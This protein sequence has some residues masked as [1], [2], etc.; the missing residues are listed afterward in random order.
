MGPLGRLELRWT[1]NY[2]YNLWLYTLMLLLQSPLRSTCGYKH[3]YMSTSLHPNTCSYVNEPTFKLTW[4]QSVTCLETIKFCS[5]ACGTST[6]YQD[7]WN[8]NHCYLSQHSHTMMFTCMIL[9]A[10]NYNSYHVVGHWIHRELL[11]KS[12]YCSLHCMPCI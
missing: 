8:H 9:M 6:S 5:H 10:M 11:F 12:Q 1:M 2:S 7:T 3:I 4:D